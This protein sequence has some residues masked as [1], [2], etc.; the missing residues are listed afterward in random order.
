MKLIYDISHGLCTQILLEQG[1]NKEMKIVI[2]KLVSYLFIVF[3]WSLVKIMPSHDLSNECV[4]YVIAFSFK[5]DFLHL[6]GIASQVTSCL[7][8]KN[9]R[10]K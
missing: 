3:S 10:I 4:R 7:D 1:S 6:S 2:Y 9:E 8:P 5:Q